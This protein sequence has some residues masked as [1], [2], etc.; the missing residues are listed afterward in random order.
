MLDFDEVFV[1]YILVYKVQKY[2]VGNNRHYLMINNLIYHWVFVIYFYFVDKLD[3]F[4][5]DYVRDVDSYGSLLSL[6]MY[7]ENSIFVK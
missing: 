2:L 7:L 6:L 4:H 1:H 5:F 3:N